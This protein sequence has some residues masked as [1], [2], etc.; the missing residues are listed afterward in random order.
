MTFT[1]PFN[2]LTPFECPQKILAALMFPIALLRLWL[3]VAIFSVLWIMTKFGKQTA[4][5]TKQWANPLLTFW[6]F[7]CGFWNIYNAKTN[8][9][10]ALSA[11]SSKPQIFIAN[12]VSMFDGLLLFVLTQA[13]VVTKAEV[14]DMPLFGSVLKQMEFIPVERKSLKH[15]QAVVADIQRRLEEGQSV[16]LFPQGTTAP[17]VHLTRFCS[18]GAFS[19]PNRWIL[20]LFFDFSAN[21]LYD[22]AIPF[23]SLPIVLL[24]NLTHLEIQWTLATL[25]LR[26]LILPASLP[27]HPISRRTELTLVSQKL[28]HEVQMQM[29]RI[30]LDNC[31]HRLTRVLDYGYDDLNFRSFL[32]SCSSKFDIEPS[33]NTWLNEC[34]FQ[35]FI[36]KCTR[37]FPHHSS[38]SKEHQCLYFARMFRLHSQ[39][40]FP[41]LFQDAVV[42]S[43]IPRRTWE[44]CTQIEGFETV[45]GEL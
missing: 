25:P 31:S 6:L 28:A 12:H 24:R 20:P 9:S 26:Q 3:L 13:P 11:M 34:C 32:K 2:S 19:H 41:K 44:I 16:G 1:Y 42:V 4:V 43:E 39:D 15:R 30:P 27:E 21:M 23:D 8:L 17:N 45:L 38:I 29:Y 10:R 14:F 18:Q 35:T 36:L 37:Y 40:I 5:Q 22:F 7:I 33:W